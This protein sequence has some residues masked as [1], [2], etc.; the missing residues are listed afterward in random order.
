MKKNYSSRWNKVKREK[1]YEAVWK[2]TQRFIF[3]VTT[4]AGLEGEMNFLTI[5]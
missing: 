1:I 4:M 3:T 2:P 5:K